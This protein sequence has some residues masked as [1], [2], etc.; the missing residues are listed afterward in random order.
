MGKNWYIFTLLNTWFIN[1]D[2]PLTGNSEMLFPSILNSSIFVQFAKVAGK[3]ES[4]L[5]LEQTKTFFFF[6]EGF[7]PFCFLRHRE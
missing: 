7:R 4:W 2:L 1:N 3:A 6:N 5:Y